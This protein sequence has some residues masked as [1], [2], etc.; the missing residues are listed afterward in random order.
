M[1]FGA[2]FFFKLRSLTVFLHHFST[3]HFVFLLMLLG[4]VC[5]PGLFPELLLNY[6]QCRYMHFWHKS[7]RFCIWS[8]CH[9][10]LNY[11]LLSSLFPLL[12]P[13]K[14]LLQRCSWAQITCIYGLVA[15]G[16]LF[17]KSVPMCLQSCYSHRGNAFEMLFSITSSFFLCRV[18]DKITLWTVWLG[19]TL[20]SRASFICGAIHLAQMLSGIPLLVWC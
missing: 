14:P 6:C 17:S 12:L 8:N 19:T 9:F 15:P 13:P 5:V 20:F 10:E 4:F 18:S 7:R 2:F 3:L 11:L 16:Y 1:N